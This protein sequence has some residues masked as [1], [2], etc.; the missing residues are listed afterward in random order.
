M[1]TFPTLPH[2]NGS[3]LSCYLNKIAQLYQCPQEWLK[4][5]ILNYTNNNNFFISEVQQLRSAAAAVI[6]AMSR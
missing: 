3:I 5:L 6:G 4:T 1:L 2:S